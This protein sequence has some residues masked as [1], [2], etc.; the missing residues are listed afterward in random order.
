MNNKILQI[1]FKFGKSISLKEV[2][3]VLHIFFFLTVDFGMLFSWL[4][5]K[6][7]SVNS[8]NRVKI[9]LLVLESFSGQ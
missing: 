1:S 4:A 8:R 7:L 6:T 9:L 5:F 3:E 2:H